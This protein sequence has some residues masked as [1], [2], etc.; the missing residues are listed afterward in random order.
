[1]QTALERDFGVRAR[2]VEDGSDTT[3]N[4]ARSSARMLAARDITRVLLVTYGVHTAR[5][6]RAF[7]AAGLTTV[8]AATGY[9]GSAPF[10]WQHLVH[11]AEALRLSNLALREWM[12]GLWYRLRR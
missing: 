12:A 3:A 10:G 2:W 11:N 6:R 9:V 1:M 7:A 4:N 5:A 8:P